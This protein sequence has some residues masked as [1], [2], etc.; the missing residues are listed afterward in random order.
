MN[1][2]DTIN[3]F[4]KQILRFYYKIYMHCEYPRNDDALKPQNH[5]TMF[6]EAADFK[7]NILVR[8]E[9][10]SVTIANLFN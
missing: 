6:L 9:I 5:F 8:L 1:F 4:R 3:S 10:R 2:S 7:K